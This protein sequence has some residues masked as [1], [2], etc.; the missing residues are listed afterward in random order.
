MRIRV[1]SLWLGLACT[2]ASKPHDPAAARPA[3]P[4]AAAVDLE[5]AWA[6]TPDDGWSRWLRDRALPQVAGNARGERLVH[7]WE[8]LAR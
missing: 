8:A 7:A 5:A 6:A 3:A 2:P 1:M 4:A